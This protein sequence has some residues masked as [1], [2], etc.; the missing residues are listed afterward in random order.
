[1][2]ADA[3]GSVLEC[4][5]LAPGPDWVAV[6]LES[7]ALLRARAVDAGAQEDGL[8]TRIGSA[9]SAVEVTLGSDDELPDPGRPEAVRLASQPVRLRSPGHRAVRRLLGHLTTRDP[10]R[11]LLGTIASS[12]AYTDVDGTRPSVVLVLPDERPR[13][14]I[15]ADGPWCQFTLGG[16]RHGLPYLGRGP[17]EERLPPAEISRLLVVGFGL[18]RGGQLPKVVLGTLPKI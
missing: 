11:P 5:V 10:G 2:R 6:D 3:P 16:R 8:R 13:L 4:L 12:I 9:L 7:G 15:D 1:M 14:G 18:P 17:G